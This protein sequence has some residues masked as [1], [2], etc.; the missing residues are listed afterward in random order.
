MSDCPAPDGSAKPVTAPLPYSQ[1]LRVTGGYEVT[2]SSMDST[3]DPESQVTLTVRRK[4][5]DCNDETTVHLSQG[6]SVEA[7]GLRLTIDRVMASTG[8][9]PPSL[10][11]K[12]SY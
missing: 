7:L 2:F 8:G 6:G 3:S 9:R 1:T 4:S 10:T 11:V 5:S 12:Y